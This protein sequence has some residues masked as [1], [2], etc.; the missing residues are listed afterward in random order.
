[1]MALTPTPT[2]LISGLPSRTLIGFDLLSFTST[3][4]FHGIKD[5][6]NGAH[7]LYG[8]ATEVFS[9]RSGEWLF[10]GPLGNNPHS[11]ATEHEQ[12]ETQLSR[13]VPSSQPNLDIR[14]R[15]W[16]QQTEVIDF[17]DERS[18]SGQRAAMRARANLG[19]IWR[20]GGLLSY[21]RSV[22]G[23][24]H[25]K[26]KWEQIE[27]MRI[28]LESG[29]ISDPML[30]PSSDLERADWG[31]LTDLISPAVLTRIL[32]P[33]FVD[34]EGRSIWR[35]S[36]ASSAERDQEKIPGLS[37]D[38]VRDI[39][40]EK[41]ADNER[42]LNFL[43]VNLIQTWPDG[44]IGR[45]R[46]EGA[47]DR[48]WALGEL[49]QRSAQDIGAKCVSAGEAQVLG[50]F[51][52]TFI[53]VLTL[54]NLSCLEQWKRILEL[55]LTCQTALETR[56]G[57]F[58]K[59][60]Q[61]LGLQLRHFD[62]V[63]GGLFEMDGDDGGAFLRKLLM[64]FKRT[65]SDL[66]ASSANNVKKEF[67][68]LEGWIQ[69]NFGWELQREAIVRRGMLELEDGEQVE[70]DLYDSEDEEAGEYAPVVVD[71]GENA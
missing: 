22:Y 37:A 4:N 68:E 34:I 31:K 2:I 46:T 43:P 30:P 63:E 32:G 59:L 54:M 15:H 65:I 67:K 38:E 64:G 50:E 62:D 27:D 40:G 42:A 28:E 71:L 18:E 20:N 33:P 11:N 14:F 3:P 12:Q 41:T 35:I 44:A 53:M 61:V 10:V 21:E 52:V 5:I 57:L 25:K 19:E 47:K 48:S 8:G 16:N 58:V 36:S 66:P 29:D 6:T 24:Q 49:I 13:Q 23:K 69:Q 60:L 55:L 45:A 1:M 9:L 39:V 56:E 51:Q 17:L 7:F 26:T 70:M